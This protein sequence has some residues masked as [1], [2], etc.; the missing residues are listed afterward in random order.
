[1]GRKSNMICDYCGKG[2][3]KR[4]GAVKKDK[5]HCCSKK[6]SNEL[7][8]KNRVKRIEDKF[9]KDIRTILHELYVEQKLSTRKIAE[10]IDLSVNKTQEYLHRYNIPLRHGSEAVK[11][12]WIN[13]D[14][15]RKLSRKTLLK[16]EVRDKIRQ[17]QQTEEYKMKQSISKTGKKNGMY[18]VTGENHHNWDSERT[19]E[20]RVAERKTLKDSRWRNSV[21][22]RDNYICQVCGYDKGGCLVSHHLNSYD[23]HK[24]DRYNIDNGITLCDTCHKEFHSAYGYGNN[25]KEQFDE[26]INSRHFFGRCF[27]YA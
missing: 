17:A 25:T 16:K 24:K 6:C 8:H 19:H 18:G 13:N 5:T 9:N 23:K 10:I 21:F 12:Q 11:T 26:F 27:Y 1:M 20:Q 7:L 3:Y 22:E 14:E 2:F 4:P 15:R